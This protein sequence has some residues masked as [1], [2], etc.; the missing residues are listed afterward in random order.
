MA[1]MRCDGQSGHYL[2]YISK[3]SD[4]GGRRSEFMA[5]TD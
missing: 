4:D 3:L 5:I 2:P 1:V